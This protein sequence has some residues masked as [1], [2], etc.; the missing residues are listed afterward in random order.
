MQ[1][2]RLRLT[3]NSFGCD[4]DASAAV[5][6]TKPITI[7]Y[8]DWPGWTCWAIAEKQGFFKKHNV[9]VTLKWF[10]NYTDSLNA[11]AAQS[12]RRQLPDLE[13]QHGAAGPGPG[14][15]SRLD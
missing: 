7:G 6:T 1:P 12:G 14:R 9:D 15:E 13:R 10:P 3:R 5:D 2:P 8:S 4:N 11:F